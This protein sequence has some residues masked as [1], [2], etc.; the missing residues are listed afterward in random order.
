MAIIRKPDKS[1]I[2]A[3]GPFKAEYVRLTAEGTSDSFESKLANPQFAT[4][5]PIEGTTN[6]TNMQATVSGKTVSLTTVV[7]TGVYLVTVYGD[8]V[9]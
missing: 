6:G 4:I 8:D 1:M 7:D 5:E 9:W 3:H 2:V